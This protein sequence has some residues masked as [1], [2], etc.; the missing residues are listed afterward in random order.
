M[1]ISQ[2]CKCNETDYQFSNIL[3]RIWHLIKR[4]I[5]RHKQWDKRKHNPSLLL[6][7]DRMLK[8]IGLSRAD[9]VRISNAHS[10]RVMFQPELNDMKDRSGQNN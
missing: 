9:V 6:M 8:D 10:F 3:R 5:K 7:E 1:M 4:T 2:N